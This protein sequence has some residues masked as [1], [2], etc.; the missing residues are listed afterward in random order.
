MSDG[1]Q[2]P[3]LPPHEAVRRAPV[4]RV[5]VRDWV[6]ARAERAKAMAVSLGIYRSKADGTGLTVGNPPSS[7][8]HAGRLASSI[9]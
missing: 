5:D 6:P 2:L 4:R 9:A 3:A 7:R 8:R 1:R